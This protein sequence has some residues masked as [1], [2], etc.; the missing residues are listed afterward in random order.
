MIVITHPERVIPAIEFFDNSS[1][2]FIT[3]PERHLDK[4]N[5][6]LE[7]SLMSV[8]KWEGIWHESFTDQAEFSGEKLLSYIHCMTINTQK[9]PKIYDQLS[10]DDLMK[11]IEYMEDPRS[12]W[13]I[14]PS[15][16]KKKGKAHQTAEQLYFAMIQYGIPWEC[17]K[18]HFNRLLALLDFCDRKGS[19]SG[20]GG[21]KKK[22]E[23]ELME[24]Y[25]AMNDK[26]R[27]RFNSKG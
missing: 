25:R 12:A 13:T 9:D 21:Q 27:K 11:I 17:E 7:H 1:Q 20:Y 4:M 8:A 16:A 18:W 3:I 26:N 14:N 6:Q 22:T 24:M 19:V 23:R 2:E 10:N 15:R 5:L